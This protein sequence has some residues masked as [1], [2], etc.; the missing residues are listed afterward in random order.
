MKHIYTFESFLNESIF[1]TEFMLEWTI[2]GKES[3]TLISKSLKELIEYVSDN[4]IKKYTIKGRTNN[5][6]ET[7]IT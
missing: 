1:F 4:K 5:R 3:N 6:W 2:P 7:L